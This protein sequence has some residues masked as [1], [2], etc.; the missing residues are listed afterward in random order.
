MAL[1]GREVIPREAEF[2]LGKAKAYFY[3]ES[4]NGAQ[5][6]EGHMGHSFTREITCED[7]GIRP[8]AASLVNCGEPQHSP[9]GLGCLVYG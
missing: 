1:P 5:G 7:K 4:G 9:N 6:R 3:L 2:G 8:L